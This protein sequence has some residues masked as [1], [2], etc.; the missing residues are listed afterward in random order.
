MS[1]YSVDDAGIAMLGGLSW[2]DF[3][4]GV[5]DAVG[6][7][8]VR[9]VIVVV[10][11]GLGGPAYPEDVSGLREALRRAETSGKPFVAA[12]V[13][14]AVGATYD[15]ALACHH[16]I[17]ADDPTVRIGASDPPSGLMSGLGGTQR[18]PRLL[19]VQRAL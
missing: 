10:G 13:G 14:R 2:E 5:R 9:G 7:T 3:G 1:G 12:I 16:R 18:L 11:T 15:V 6:D 8:R 17:A 4:R 19:G